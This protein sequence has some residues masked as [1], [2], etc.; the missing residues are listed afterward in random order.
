L[1]E[2]KTS[3][4]APFVICVARAFE[5]A[6]EY[7]CELSIAGKTSVSDAAAKTVTWACVLADAPV[8]VASAVTSRMRAARFSSAPSPRST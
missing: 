6:N 1:A 7:F 5:P 3:A 4:G 2:A 8:A